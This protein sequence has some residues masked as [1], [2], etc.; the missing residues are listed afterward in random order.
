MVKNIR[1]RFRKLNEKLKK[2][3]VQAINKLDKLVEQHREQ[4]CV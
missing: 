2:L 4:L 3:E 1:T